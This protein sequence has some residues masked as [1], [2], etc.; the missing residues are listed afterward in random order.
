M[1]RVASACGVT[2]R[3]RMDVLPSPLS[4]LLVD[5]SPPLTMTEEGLFAEV[6]YIFLSASTFTSPPASLPPPRPMKAICRSAAA[7]VR[8]ER[9]W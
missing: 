2:D 4:L 7:L 5:S 1:E 8:E 3:P 9:C 6:E